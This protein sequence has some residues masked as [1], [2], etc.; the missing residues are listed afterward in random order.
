MRHKSIILTL[1]SVIELGGRLSAQSLTFADLNVI[2][3][4]VAV[5]RTQDVG[6]DYTWV[7]GTDDIKYDLSEVMTLLGVSDM[8]GVTIQSVMSDG[9]LDSEL[10]TGGSSSGWRNEAGDWC[11][12]S[13]ATNCAF[14]CQASVSESTMTFLKIGG[15]QSYRNSSLKHLTEEI[16][17]TA[18][19]V[20][21]TGTTKEDNKAVVLE[22]KLEFVA[23]APP[24]AV[25]SDLNN[26]ETIDVN[27]ES[28]VGKFHEGLTADVD[29]DAIL[30][31]LGVSALSEVTI[32]AVQ[33]N[34]TLDANYQ[35][36]ST[37]GWRNAAGD[38]Q[39]WGSS[40]YICVKSD[41]SLSDTQIKYVG[42]INGNTNTPATYTATFAFM[43][44]TEL[45]AGNDCVTLKVN[46]IYKEKEVAPIT[47]ADLKVADTQNINIYSETGYNYEG[48]T[49]TAD[50]DAIL[51]TLGET[52]LDNVTIYAVASDGTLDDDYKLGTTDGWR[53]A[54]GDWS[55]WGNSATR[56]CVKFDAPSF[57]Y[58]GGYGEGEHM[59]A[60]TTYTA[61][62]AFV[63]GKTAEDNKAV[64]LNLNL[65]YEYSKF[66]LVVT[67]AKYATF[68]APFDVTLPAGVKAYKV[69]GVTGSELD[70][71]EVATTVPACTVV[72]LNSE[73]PVNTV[74]EGLDVAD[75]TSY[76]TGLLTA[77]LYEDVKAPAG[78]YVLQDQGEGAKF[79]LVNGESPTVKAGHAY[80][81]A[82]SA[83]VKA[84]GF[85]AIATAIAKI[86]AEKA[87]KAGIYNLQGQQLNSLQ[88][89]INIVNGKKILVK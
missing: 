33:S 25:Y 58:I 86:E 72:V 69:T 51:A 87:E 7:N 9:T 1:L 49:A 6:T 68:V 55:S 42:G 16:T 41:F 61:K 48:E 46:L 76:T 40:A 10:G 62:F 31:K 88:R 70:M 21:Y 4:K 3:T 57:S 13:D 56:F 34:G 17:Y 80:L 20:A 24:A 52:T 11:A 35:L 82:P 18:K 26:I 83:G 53:D 85:D 73:T 32:Y 5:T 27:V 14:R 47:F 29:V 89:G 8:T 77:S 12:W 28:T 84:F 43:K 71:E 74:V 64:V 60:P 79:Y 44:G 81:T 36:G 2:G 15:Y 66:N 38:W 65:I 54:N 67:D 19:Y 50:I 22:A 23:P 59:T 63:V 45:A 30:T 39:S 75:Q 37:D 78:S